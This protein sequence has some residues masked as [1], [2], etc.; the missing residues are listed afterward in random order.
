MIISA[1]FCVFYAFLVMETTCDSNLVNT[2]LYHYSSF[3]GLYVSPGSFRVIFCYIIHGNH[4]IQLN[5]KI[6]YNIS[7][8][9]SFI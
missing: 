1:I 4:R 9:L 5:P 2:F 8:N 7:I 6:S 3:Y